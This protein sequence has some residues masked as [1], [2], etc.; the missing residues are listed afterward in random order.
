[1]VVPC[2]EGVSASEAVERGADAVPGGEKL[3]A[4]LREGAKDA[5]ALKE[6]KEDAVAG[7]DALLEELKKGLGET[8]SVAEATGEAEDDKD[9]PN[10]ADAGCEAVVAGDV[11]KAGLSEGA[12][13]GG[14]LIVSAEEAVAETEFEGVTERLAAAVPLK[15]AL[16]EDDFVAA[17]E[18]EASGDSDAEG[19]LVVD[20]LSSEV[21]DSRSEELWEKEGRGVVVPGT[22]SEGA[23]GESEAVPLARA[24]L[25]A[26]VVTP[27]LDEK[28]SEG[29]PDAEAGAGV[30]VSVLL[31]ASLAPA[32]AVARVLEEA[33]RDD[34]PVALNAVVA[35]LTEEAEPNTVGDALAKADM[36]IEMEGTEVRVR[37]AEASA[38]MEAG[39]EADMAA[40]PLPVCDA[41]TV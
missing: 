19:Q 31:C 4:P 15:S 21:P 23:A 14:G 38:E 9:A 39:R 7:S 40:E 1:V 12:L 24:V 10:E 11:E 3:A 41:L 5:E 36:E 2:S 6:P 8:L 17:A 34:Q 26:L 37:V 25:L 18:R 30:G 13:D 20:R 27:G 22:V 29:A 32:E 33:H 35:L 28:M 16:P